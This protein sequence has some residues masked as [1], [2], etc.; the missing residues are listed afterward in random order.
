MKQGE[1]D[2]RRLNIDRYV[3]ARDR[4]VVQVDFQR[5][6]E[7]PAPKFPGGSAL[8]VQFSDAAPVDNT[9]AAGLEHAQWGSVDPRTRHGC[10]DGCESR[11][12]VPSLAGPSG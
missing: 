9:A 4:N 6:P 3:V 10:T 8:R 1:A 7:P 5:E 11:Q 12:P 2:M